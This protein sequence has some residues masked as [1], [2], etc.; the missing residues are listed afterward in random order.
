MNYISNASVRTFGQL[1]GC[2]MTSKG[3]LATARDHAEI[4][5]VSVDIREMLK[6]IGMIGEIAGTPLF[7][8]ESRVFLETMAPF[9]AM[10]AIAELAHAVPMRTRIAA[11]SAIIAGSGP[12]EGQAKLCGAFDLTDDQA[13]LHKAIALVAESDELSR[14]IGETGI[15]FL[16]NQLRDTLG[17]ATDQVFFPAILEGISPSA[18]TGTDAEAFRYDVAIALKGLVLGPNSKPFLVVDPIQAIDLALMQD[19]GGQAF[20]DMTFGGGTVSG[21]PVFVSGGIPF[22]ADTS[23]GTRQ[24]V[25]GDAQGLAVDTGE[26]MLI[27]A[28]EANLTVDDV[29]VNLW[30]KNLSALLAE[31]IFAASVVRSGALAVISGSYSA[32]ETSP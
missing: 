24:L 1:A 11:M 23:P 20:P 19:P 22:N 17:L 18:A 21:L 27:P 32:P 5:G 30:Q 26:I 29:T 9:S 7:Q 31:R 25:I 6:G 8:A 10:D 15:A 28:S 12:S 2:L 14:G 16:L 3:R 13:A 4:A